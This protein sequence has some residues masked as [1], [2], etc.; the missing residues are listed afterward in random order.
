MKKKHVTSGFQSVSFAMLGILFQ[1][2]DTL[3]AATAVSHQGFTWTFSSD[4]PTGTFA[5]GEPWVVAPVT[6]TAISPQWDGNNNGSMKNPVA[7]ARNGFVTW[8]DATSMPAAYRYD[9]TKNVATQLPL[10]LAAGD[11]I[12]SSKTV[13]SFPNYV[14]KV[15]V[16]TV[17]ASAPPAGSFRPGPYGTNR[18]VRFNKSQINWGLLK[19]FA[20]VTGTPSRAQIDYFTPPLPWWEWGSNWAGNNL[21]GQWNMAA[22]NDGQGRPSTYGREIARKWGDVALWLNLNHTQADKE[23]AMIYAIQCGIDIHS[24]TTNGG[25]FYHDGGH[26]CGRKFPVVMAAAALND[27]TLKT[28]AANPDIFQE[29]TQ[30]WIVTQS[31]V[32]RTVVSPKVTYSQQ[33]VGMAEWGV[34][35]RYEPIQDDS[36]WADG[37][38]YRFTV[39]PAMSGVVVAVRLMGLQSTWNHPA[40]FQYN[41]RFRSIN[42]LDRFAE[43]MLA[44]YGGSAPSTSP[45]PP[46][47]PP[48]E[49]KIGSRIETIR[50]T[51]VRITGALTATLLGTQPTG[52]KGTI[53]A[54]P[55]VESGITWWQVDYDTGVDGWSGAD[56]FILGT[57]QPPPAG[58]AVGKRIETIRSTNVRASGA[59]TAT[60]LGT[61]ATGSKGTI[62]AGSV[63]ES[64]IIWW[65]VDYDTGVDGWS[66]EDNFKLG[67]DQAPPAKPSVPG[68]LEVTDP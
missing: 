3:P 11:V 22:Y 50:S 45:P 54:G 9:A 49:L 33:H 48:P 10:A 43:N 40:I 46:P 13:N 41:E 30:T 68:G 55:V 17:L 64:G 62:T 21:C 38:P 27:S 44:T 6:V 58:F 7:G 1:L 5:N 66:G 23:R 12:A 4:R 8:P 51:N 60:L 56:N 53:I 29:D 65:Q 67:T 36:R 15:A 39:W 32:G 28:F 16:L 20:P 18:T 26:K 57:D 61:Q 59:L 34:R 19:S 63:I 42:G 35:H 14:E 25:G 31:D 37:S 24:Y 52:S 47:P 2:V